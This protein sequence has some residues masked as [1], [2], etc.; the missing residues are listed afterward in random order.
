MN[1]L[2]GA[3][4]AA[5]AILLL[6]V[7]PVAAGG[8]ATVT[9]DEASGEPV[10]GEPIDV[11]FTVLQHGQTPASWTTATVVATN[12]VTG[13]SVRVTA[14][15][16][17]DDG[18]F[19]ATLT[20]PEPG[21]WTWRVELGELEN[22]SA[23][24]ALTVRAADGTLPAI[25]AATVV[26]IVEQSRAETRDEL[27]AEYE[28]RLDDIEQQLTAR[29]SEALALE[30]RLDTAMRERDSLLQRIDGLEAGGASGAV[31]PASVLAVV[32]IAV[33]AAAVTAFA[34]LALGASSG[35][36]RV[37]EISPAVDAVTTKPVANR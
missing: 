33:L 22:W 34:M 29:R 26:A 20:V 27:R 28:G 18:H 8:W 35:A 23:P 4:L 16:T 2:L 9:P 19:T 37:R 21:I 15:S 32:L 6:A 11:G 12:A 24:T 17:G 31:S 3:L 1:R 25:D 10:A 13:A 14:S 5:L 30:A 7:T 36:R